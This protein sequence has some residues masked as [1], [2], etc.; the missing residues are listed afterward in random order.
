MNR[1]SVFFSIFLKPINNFLNPKVPKEGEVTRAW[2]TV[3]GTV[4]QAAAGVYTVELAFQAFSIDTKEPELEISSPN[5]LRVEF[6]EL[7]M[8]VF[9]QPTFIV[10]NPTKKLV[11]IKKM[12]MEI[13][14]SEVPIS[15]YKTFEKACRNNNNNSRMILEWTHIAKF[16]WDNDR[17]IGVYEGRVSDS[18]PLPVGI[19]SPQ[20]PMAG[21]YGDPKNKGKWESERCYRATIYALKSPE[22]K[23]LLQTSFHFKLS[24]KDLKGL[25]TY[26]RTKPLNQLNKLINEMEMTPKNFQLLGFDFSQEPLYGQHVTLDTLEKGCKS[27]L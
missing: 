9:A 12:C 7:Y 26:P 18:L 1:I 27:K 15:P 16:G 8:N 17:D 13:Q 3:F 22:D 6:S 24:K 5:M 19:S 14:D 25:K 11:I 21:F 10:T 2:L 20:T 4:V 23:Q